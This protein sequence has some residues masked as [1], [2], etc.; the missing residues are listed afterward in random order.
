M[1]KTVPSRR[2]LSAASEPR[3]VLDLEVVGV[4]EHLGAEPLPQLDD[5]ADLLALPGPSPRLEM[6][7]I[8]AAIRIIL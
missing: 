4:G 7:K 3:R 1:K 6:L 8:R 5:L 2:A